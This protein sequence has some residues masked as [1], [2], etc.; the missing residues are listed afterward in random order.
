MCGA[1]KSGAARRFKRKR[2]NIEDHKTKEIKAKA[3]DTKKKVEAEK[4]KQDRIEQG[5]PAKGALDR[6][7]S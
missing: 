6:F 7:M 5:L 1:G 4:R 2:Q 3:G